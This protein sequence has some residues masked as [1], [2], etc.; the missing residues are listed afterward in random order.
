MK[1]AK[2]GYDSHDEIDTFC[3]H[4]GFELNSNYCPNKYCIRNCGEEIPCN[5]DACFCPDCGSK[6]EYYLQCLINPSD[7][8]N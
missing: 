4:C 7:Y 3:M 8:Q 1:C 6:T 2:C 5:E